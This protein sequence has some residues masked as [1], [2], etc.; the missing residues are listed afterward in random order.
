MKIKIHRCTAFSRNSIGRALSLSLFFNG[1]RIGCLRTGETLI[2]EL[3]ASEGRLC[4]GFSPGDQGYISP[5]RN[6]N[7][8]VRN[9]SLTSAELCLRS[10]DEGCEFDVGS[11]LWVMFDFLGLAYLPALKSAA[12]YVKRKLV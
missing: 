6:E 2:I 8:D 9:A 4:V 7:Q 3:P 5:H 11:R 12:F 10:E 1:Q